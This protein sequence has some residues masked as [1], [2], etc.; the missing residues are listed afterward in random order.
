MEQ[1]KAPALS[2]LTHYSSKEKKQK[3]NKPEY[4]SD[5]YKLYQF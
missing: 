3:Q 4:F 2:S 1:K 5:Y